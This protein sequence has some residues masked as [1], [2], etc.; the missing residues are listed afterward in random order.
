MSHFVD[1]VAGLDSKMLLIFVENGERIDQ[2][3]K[4]FWNTQEKQTHWPKFDC[5][6]S[7]AGKN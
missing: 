3:D 5:S 7:E 1:K 2:I 6:L 4:K